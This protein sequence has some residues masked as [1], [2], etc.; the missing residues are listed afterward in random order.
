MRSFLPFSLYRSPPLSFFSKHFSLPCLTQPFCNI[1]FSLSPPL[2]WHVPYLIF[3]FFFHSIPF[4]LFP[5]KTIFQTTAASLRFTNLCFMLILESQ[6]SCSTS[7]VTSWGFCS[8]TSTALR[9]KFV[10][11]AFAGQWEALRWPPTHYVQVL[12]AFYKAKITLPLTLLGL[13]MS[14]SPR[15][16]PT[17][18]S[19]TRRSVNLSETFIRQGWTPKTVNRWSQYLSRGQLSKAHQ[20]WTLRLYHPSIPFVD[21]SKMVVSL[22]TLYLQILRRLN[23]WLLVEQVTEIQHLLF[24]VDSKHSLELERLSKTTAWT[25]AGP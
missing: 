5:I 10:W 11:K 1:L 2:L 21:D 20:V 3:F 19:W 12:L 9:W 25:T 23:I 18:S 22:C 8:W 13:W 7:N 14:L 16:T 24:A 4:P 6:Q 17:R 15:C